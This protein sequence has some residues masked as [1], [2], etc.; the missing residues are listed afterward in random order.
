MADDRN[1]WPSVAPDGQY[2]LF[3]LSEAEMLIETL[4]HRV[5]ALNQR[6]AEIMAHT[7]EHGPMPE[8]A[9]RFKAFKESRNEKNPN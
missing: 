1:Q 4:R 5:M 2:E 3:P 9:D 7:A 8:F 6:M